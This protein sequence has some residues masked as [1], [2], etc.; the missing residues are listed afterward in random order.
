M[1][2]IQKGLNCYKLMD[3]VNIMSNWGI[4]YFFDY[5]TKFRYLTITL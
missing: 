3:N 2:N 5:K 4:F 1:T